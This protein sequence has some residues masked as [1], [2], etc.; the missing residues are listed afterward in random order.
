M[1]K[2]SDELVVIMGYYSSYMIESAKLLAKS[3]F[4]QGEEASRKLLRQ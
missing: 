3:Q 1:A 2:L 4:T